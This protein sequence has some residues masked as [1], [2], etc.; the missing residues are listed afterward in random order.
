MKSYMR[1]TIFRWYRPSDAWKWYG[2]RRL[3]ANQ[4]HWMM[5]LDCMEKKNLQISPGGEG[6]D[7]TNRRGGV[8]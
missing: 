4:Q 8:Y 7:R 3:V 6:S 5:K 1:A 2:E